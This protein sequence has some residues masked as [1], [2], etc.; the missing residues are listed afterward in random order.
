MHLLQEVEQLAPEL[1]EVR[2]TWYPG[3]FLKKLLRAQPVR[4]VYHGQ[5]EEWDIA[6]PTG[7]YRVAEGTTKQLV[8]ETWRCHL[9]EQEYKRV[10]QELHQKLR[11]IAASLLQ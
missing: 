3:W 2:L 6:S 8:I 4:S 5:G 1:W 9:A 11:R 7:W 10:Q